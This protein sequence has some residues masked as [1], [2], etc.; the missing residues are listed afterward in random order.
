[1][2]GVGAGVVAVGRKA[3]SGCCSDSGACMPVE[4]FLRVETAHARPM[5]V[6]RAESDSSVYFVLIWLFS[7]CPSCP[8]N[9]VNLPGISL[10]EKTWRS[11][12]PCD[13]CSLLMMACLLR[14]IQVGDGRHAVT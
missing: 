13:G 9:K 7:T 4:V 10:S 3:G 5:S 8:P 2:C 6:C 11:E 1:M 12:A 14:G